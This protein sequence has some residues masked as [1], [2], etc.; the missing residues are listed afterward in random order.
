MGEGPTLAERIDL[1]VEFLNEN[2]PGWR[3]TI[4]VERLDLLDLDW[5]IL[6]QWYRKTHDHQEP[7]SGYLEAMHTLI[8]GYDSDW[9]HDHGFTEL[10]SA[11]WSELQEAW[12]WELTGELVT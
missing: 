8:G 5:C 6:G 7:T 4:D 9:S 12:K 11:T 2:A 3:D 10:G 1:G